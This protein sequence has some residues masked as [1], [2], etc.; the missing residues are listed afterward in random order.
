M[1]HSTFSFKQLDFI[2]KRIFSSQF[3]IQL[4]L[5]WA[6][7][8]ENVVALENIFKEYINIISLFPLSLQQ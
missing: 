2:V 4:S 3:R 5:A 7:G 8:K 6:L 1:I